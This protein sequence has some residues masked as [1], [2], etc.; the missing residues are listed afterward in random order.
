MKKLIAGRAASVGRVKGVV[1]LVSEEHPIEAFPNG[2]I[3]VCEMTNPDMTIQIRKAGAI[4]TDRGGRSAHAAV[5]AREFKIPCIVGTGDA[6]KQIPHGARV[7][8]VVSGKSGEGVVYL[9]SK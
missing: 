7:S 9:L 3:L 5:V 4:V 8:V 6:T 2:H 1:Y